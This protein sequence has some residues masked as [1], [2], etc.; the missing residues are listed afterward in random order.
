MDERDF[1]RRFALFAL[2]FA[3]SGCAPAYQPA[4]DMTAV[5]PDVYH[6]DLAACR[7]K[8]GQDFKTGRSFA[9]G[10]MFADS[11]ILASV[12]VAAV[13]VIG[14]LFA[15]SNLGLAASTGALSG[16]TAGGAVGAAT[17]ASPG[18]ASS[19]TPPPSSDPK[20]A[21][22]R[23]LTDYGYKLQAPQS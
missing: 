10:P 1:M 17:G 15:T 21:L 6:D 9:G 11:V 14:Y 19:A 2:C 4:V 5:N 12:G 3:V 22:D 16:A 13:P 7:T 23:C 20:A 8:T 18:K